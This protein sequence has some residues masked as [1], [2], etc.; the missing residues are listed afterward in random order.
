MHIH[1]H[2]RTHRIHSPDPIGIKI[3]AAAIILTNAIVLPFQRFKFC[4]SNSI[5]RR[6]RILFFHSHH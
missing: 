3:V 1:S 5:V 4:V 2:S 6:N